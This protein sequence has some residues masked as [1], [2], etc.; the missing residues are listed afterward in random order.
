MA[1]TP[2]IQTGANVRA[3]MARRGVTQ[4]TLAAHLNLPQSAVSNRLR[5]KT[6]FNVN[7]LAAA[8]AFLGVPLSALLPVEVAA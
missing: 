7:E 1:Q 4:Q 8:A 2:A 3:E 6:A 5:G